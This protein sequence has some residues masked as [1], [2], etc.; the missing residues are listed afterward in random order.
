MVIS[1]SCC[2]TSGKKVD[3]FESAYFLLGRKKRYKNSE[4]K[5][6]FTFNV[7]KSNTPENNIPA[8]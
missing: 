4:E 2:D 7:S 3:M 6:S 5:I 8:I 1:I